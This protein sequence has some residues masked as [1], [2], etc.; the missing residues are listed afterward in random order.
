V[1][2]GG[3]VVD[4]FGPDIVDEVGELA[5]I[6]QIPVMEKEAG[7]RIVR[8]PIDVLDAIRVKGAGPP[9]Q[10]MDLIALLHQGLGQVGSVLSGDASDERSFHLLLAVHVGEGGEGARGAEAFLLQKPLDGP[11]GHALGIA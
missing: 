4:L 9:D 8:V 11:P 7:L 1:T 3:E 10:S 6:G 5:R 2:L